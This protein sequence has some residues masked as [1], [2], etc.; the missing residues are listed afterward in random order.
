MDWWE[1]DAL[2]SRAPY[3]WA[4]ATRGDRPWD[5]LDFHLDLG[6]GRVPKARMGI[7]LRPSPGATSMAIDFETLLPT[8]NDRFPFSVQQG[9]IIELTRD[10]YRSLPGAHG[11]I[12]DC[13]PFPDA[14]I[15]SIVTH[16]CFEHVGPGF[17][18][19]MEECYRILAWDGVM[20]IVVPLFPSYAAVSEYD[21]KRYFMEGTFDG[22]CQE[23]P[24]GTS[25]YDGFSERYNTCCFRKLDED[26]SPPTAPEKQWTRDDAREMR[27]TLW[28]NEHPED[29]PPEAQDRKDFVG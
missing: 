28:K 29:T 22:F 17:E 23:L 1:Y 8:A 11:A 19:L 24:G 14:S 9:A 5:N 21:H 25:M 2:P 16:H 3:D 7:D 20:R 18:R 27:V 15:Q 6:C 13:L 26:M 10:Q 12:R 4:P